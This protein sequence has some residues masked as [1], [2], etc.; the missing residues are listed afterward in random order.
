MVNEMASSGV[1]ETVYISSR[2]DRYEE[3]VEE[4]KADP[5]DSAVYLWR[6]S[7]LPMISPLL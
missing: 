2:S 5:F 7:T 4:R 1:L 3:A 6:M